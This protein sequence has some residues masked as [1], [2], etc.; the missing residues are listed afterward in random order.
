MNFLYSFVLQVIILTELCYEFFNISMLVSVICQILIN[1]I[2]VVNH[3]L[4]VQNQVTLV[5]IPFSSLRLDS[6][7]LLVFKFF[8]LFLFHLVLLLQ[9]LYINRSNQVSVHFSKLV[10]GIFIIKISYIF[11]VYLSKD[12]TDTHTCDHHY[13]ESQNVVLCTYHHHFTIFWTN[14]DFRQQLS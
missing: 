6:S 12:F 13:C 14:R 1:E 11:Y 4:R 7:Y 8:Q 5:T 10:I 9:L 2:K 3:Q